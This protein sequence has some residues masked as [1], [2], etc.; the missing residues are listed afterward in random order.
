MHEAVEILPTINQPHELANLMSNF[1][2]VIN[3][4]IEHCIV[5]LDNV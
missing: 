1:L 5:F 2:W 4:Y 3:T